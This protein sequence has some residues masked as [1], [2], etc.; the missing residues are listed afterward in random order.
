MKNG[1]I[2]INPSILAKT[3]GEE[4]TQGSPYGGMRWMKKG[5]R[6][7]AAALQDAK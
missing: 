3:G 5:E 6:S 2:N 1:Y 4:E 7:I